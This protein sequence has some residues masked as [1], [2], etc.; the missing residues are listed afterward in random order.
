MTPPS[1]IAR[2]PSPWAQA[3]NPVP[4]NPIRSIPGHYAGTH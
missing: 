2:N 1:I 3:I 4:A